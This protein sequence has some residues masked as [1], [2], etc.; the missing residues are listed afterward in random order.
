MAAVMETI[1]PTILIR[2]VRDFNVDDLESVRGLM[3]EY[4][5]YLGSNPAGAANICLVGYDDELAGLPRPYVAPGVLLFAL[6]N[7]EAAGCVG[8]KAVAEP[9]A[10]ELKRL[11]VGSAFRGLGLGR[12]LM[13]AAINHARETRAKAVLLDTVPAAMPEANRLYAAMGFRPVERYNDNDVADVV[14]FRLDL[15]EA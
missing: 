11:W 10:L 8:L 5:A 14:F 13:Q 12:K 9:G 1:K 7:G 6:V 15:I 4:A 3:R 2:A